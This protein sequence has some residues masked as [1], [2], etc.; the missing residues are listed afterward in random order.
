MI[1]LDRVIHEPVRLRIAMV[2]SGLEEADFNFLLSALELSRGNL[3]S[4]MAKLEEAGYVEIDKRFEGKLP[5]T[6]YRLT[7]SGREA[8]EHYWAGLEEIRRLGPT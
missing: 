5:R 4:H 7:A 6:T 1:D 3:S 2:L 8:L